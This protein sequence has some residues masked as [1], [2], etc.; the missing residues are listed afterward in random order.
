MH[1]AY[2]VDASL[3]ESDSLFLGMSVSPQIVPMRWQVVLGLS[4]S[5]RVRCSHRCLSICWYCAHG[6]VQTGIRP[7]GRQDAEQLARH[8]EYEIMM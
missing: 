3:K 2:S 7:I 5:V 1:N 4:G 6:S 8:R